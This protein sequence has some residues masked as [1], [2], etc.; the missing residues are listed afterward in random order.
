MST[1]ETAL[2]AIE[3]SEMPEDLPANVEPDFVYGFINGATF[4][5][6]LT[7]EEFRACYKKQSGAFGKAN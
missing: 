3:Q 2:F 5:Q 1:L 6:R 7:L 4:E